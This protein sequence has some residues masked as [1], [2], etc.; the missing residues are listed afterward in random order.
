MEFLF[1]LAIAVPLV[2]LPVVMSQRGRGTLAGLLSKPS[3][4]HRNDWIVWDTLRRKGVSLR[5]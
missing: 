1:A 5:P 3:R 2:V 4:D